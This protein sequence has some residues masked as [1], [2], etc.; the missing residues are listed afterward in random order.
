MTAVASV[1]TERHL[2]AHALGVLLILSYVWDRPLIFD[3]R[4]IGAY[5]ALAFAYGSAYLLAARLFL[6]RRTRRPPP[7]S[8]EA[9][10]A[11]AG[12]RA[13]RFLLRHL[14]MFGE[15]GLTFV[16]LLIAGINPVT[17]EVVA[18]LYGALHYPR[19]PIEICIARGL[20]VFLVAILILPYNLYA[21]ILGRWALEA[22][23]HRMP[24]VAPLRAPLG[25]Y[26]SREG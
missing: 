25:Q 4:E 7:P 5:L 3:P 2:P 9:R 23:L 20:F 26:S 8:A 21:V 15:D 13:R 14:R 18:A 10:A 17:A 16:P 6:K 19:W 22:V 12:G 11:P 1:L 24:Q